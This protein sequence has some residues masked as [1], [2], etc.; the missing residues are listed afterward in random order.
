MPFIERDPL[1][2]RKPLKP[3]AIWELEC[4]IVDVRAAIDLLNQL[5]HIPDDDSARGAALAYMQD[6]LHEHS[7]RLQEKFTVVF[8][9]VHGPLSGG[10][11]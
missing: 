8:K 4:A 6:R 1:G 2:S 11:S 10:A 3:D 7:N 9:A 5:D